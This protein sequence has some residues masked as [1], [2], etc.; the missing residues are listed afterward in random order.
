MKETPIK[1]YKNFI[2][3][4]ER[5]DILLYVNSINHK[6]R[7]E[8]IH[9]KHLISE[10]KGNSHM[11]NISN[12]TITDAITNYQSGGSDVMKEELPT[13]FHT[14]RER[15]TKHI[16]IPDINSFL[17]IVDMDDGGKIGKHYDASFEGHINYKCNISV[18]SEDYDFCVDTQTITIQQGDLYC[19]EASLYKHWTPNS[20]SKR[21]VLLSFGFMLPYDVLGRDKDDPR[22]RL[23]NRIERYFQNS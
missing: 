7:A 11:Y 5:H 10:I 16:Q 9:L 18:I 1:I 17:Q 15:I 6:S 4:R 3:E 13:V 22:V 14:L 12:N 23:S 19:F 21:R 8:N 20:F 2:E